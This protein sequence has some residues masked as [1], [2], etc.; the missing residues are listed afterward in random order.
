MKTGNVLIGS[1][2]ATSKPNAMGDI[3][4]L[5]SYIPTTKGTGYY[6]TIKRL[7]GG[8]RET[9]LTTQI[10]DKEAT[11]ANMYKSAVKAA[12]AAGVIPQYRSGDPVAFWQKHGGLKKNIAFDSYS[13]GKASFGKSH[14]GQARVTSI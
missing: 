14:R 10:F 4:A 12:S 13:K 5:G 9:L 3:Y 11:S 2:S 1:V 7:G 8:K 6:I